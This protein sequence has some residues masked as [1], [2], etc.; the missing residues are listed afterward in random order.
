MLQV[1]EID[2][3]LAV[4]LGDPVTANGDGEIFHLDMRLGYIQR[5]VAKLYRTLPKLMRNHSPKFADTFLL[6]DQEVNS[7]IITLVDANENPISIEDV[8]EVFVRYSQAVVPDPITKATSS[9]TCKATFIDEEKYLAVHYQ[10]TS[11]YE[12]S[13]QDKNIYYTFL[14]NKLYLLPKQSGPNRYLSVS[15]IMKSDVPAF[16]LEDTLNIPR[17]Y[18]D[19]LLTLTALEGMQDLGRSDKVQIYTAEINNQLSILKGYADYKTQKEGSEVN[20]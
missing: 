14:D 11:A 2:T 20:G 3:A 8:K 4:K 9:V 12:P 13:F 16:V 15:A 17:E 18:E 1:K 6:H 5:A 7:D 10:N 19:L